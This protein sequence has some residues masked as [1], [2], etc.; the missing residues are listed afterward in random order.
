MFLFHVWR[1][2]FGCLLVDLIKDCLFDW[3]FICLLHACTITGDHRSFVLACCMTDRVIV[4]DW[5]LVKYVMVCVCALCMVCCEVAAY[6]RSTCQQATACISLLVF[7][8]VHGNEHVYGTQLKR[9]C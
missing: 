9:F 2:M 6:L 4:I 7:C 5:L 8:S 3:L 1:M